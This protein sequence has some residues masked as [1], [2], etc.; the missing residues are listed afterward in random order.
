VTAARPARKAQAALLVQGLR[1]L[2]VRLRD[3]GVAAADDEPLPGHDR[4]H[5]DDPF[6]NRLEL[7]ERRG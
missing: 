4:V 1:E 3:V 7:L 2:V 6:G 5:V